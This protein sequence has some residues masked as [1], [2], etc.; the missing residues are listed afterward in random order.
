MVDGFFG[1]LDY[2]WRVIATGISFAAF[3]IGGLLLRVLVLPLLV[4][5]P[6]PVVRRR[7]ARRLVQQAFAAHVELMRRLG[8]L[9]YQVEGKEKLQRE[10]LLVLANHPTLIDVVFLVSLLPN[11]DCV[12]KGAV[13]RNP[14]MRGPVRAAGYIS[15]D[16]GAELIDDCIAAIRAGGSLVIFPEGTRS[17]SGQRL[18]LQRGAA[19]IAVRGALDIT[20]VTITCNPPTLTKGLKWYHVPSR[21]VHIHMKVGEDIRI[22]PFLEGTDDESRGDALAARRVTDYLTRYFDMNGDSSRAST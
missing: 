1:R 15:N 7:L 12:V 4:L 9:T 13:A 10:G 2:V 22:T 5:V 14:F 6:S 19:N 11:A 20:P 8:V 21:R 3:G 18:K 17:V 16:N